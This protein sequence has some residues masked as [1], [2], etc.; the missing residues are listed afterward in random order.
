MKRINYIIF[1]A[2]LLAVGLLGGCSDEEKSTLSKAVLASANTLSFDANG[3]SQK[4]ITVYADADWVSEAP[5]WVTVSPATGRGT[6]DVTISVAD[7]MREG[8]IDNPRKVSLV[9]KGCTLAS[10]TEV[11]IAQD[12]DKYRDCQSYALGELAA[13]ADETVV[14]VPEVT[15]MAVTSAGFIVADAQSLAR[16]APTNMYM[17]TAAAV[18]VGDKV[19]VKG[20]KATD[21]QALAYVAC[22]GVSVISKGNAVT[23]PAAT[24]ITGEVDTYTSASRDLISVSGILGGS[25]VTV[26]GS[27]YSVSITDAPAS[28]D[29]ASLNGHKVTVTGYFAGVAAPVVKLIAATVEDRGVV[30][31]VY[32]SDNF[33]WLQPWADAGGA[34]QTVENDG[35][36]S[37]PQ[38]YTVKDASGKLASEALVEHGYTLEQI[39]GDAIYL[40]KSYLKFGKTDYQAGLTLPAMDDIPENEALVLSF[41]WA[42]MVGSTR[43]FDPVKVIVS[44]TNGNQTVE[45]DPIEHRFVDTVDKLAWLHAEVQISGVTINKNTRIS[46]KSDGWGDTKKTTGS[47]VYRRWFIDNI[48]LVRSN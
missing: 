10:E 3:A 39:P 38:I 13:L 37:A 29:L 6:T 12:G 7:N 44:V 47:S 22:D 9:F 1:S 11:V 17:Q 8:A 16:Q 35:T 45:L 30:E 33:E 25:A 4:I 40:Q 2:L 42:P 32:F 26:E 20:M 34:G 28:L 46:I 19:S 43:K 41:D 18:S 21:S 27:T 15:V 5:D 23:Y 48:K 36:G 31:V 24:D 14:S